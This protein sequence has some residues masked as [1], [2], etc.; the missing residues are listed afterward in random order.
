MQMIMP[1]MYRLWAWS[2]NH[3]QQRHY[4]RYVSLHTHTAEG[5]ACAA[6]RVAHLLLLVAGFSGFTAAVLPVRWRDGVHRG[7][8]FARGMGGVG[9]VG[10]AGP[11]LACVV[12][13]LH[14]AE[15]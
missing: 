4:P 14:E 7:A 2:T 1:Q 15:D 11:G 9:R 6:G 12:V 8:L 5:N 3:T 10:K 13:K